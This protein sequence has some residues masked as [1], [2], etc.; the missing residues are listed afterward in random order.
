M[1]KLLINLKRHLPTA[2]AALVGTALVA[3]AL[4]AQDPAASPAPGEGPGH[5]GGGGWRHHGPGGPGGMFGHGLRRIR[6]ALGLTDT[7]VQQIHDILKANRAQVQPLVQSLMTEK[8]AE[9][10]LIQAPTVDEPAI[11][12]QAAKVAAIEADLA[13]LHARIASQIRG[14]L[15]PEQIQKIGTFQG[16]MDGK[17]DGFMGHLFGHLGR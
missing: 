14:L 4:H 11:R 16:M 10:A 9:R 15:T 8:R 1:T 7:Q 17:I 5:H 13:V 2:A 12:A 3:T 6:E